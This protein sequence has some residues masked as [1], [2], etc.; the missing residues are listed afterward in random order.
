V[1]FSPV[2]VHIDGFG[3]SLEMRGGRR[4]TWGWRLRWVR[5]GAGGLVTDHVNS[6]QLELAVMAA[7]ARW[8]QVGDETNADEAW[9]H[10][11]GHGRQPEES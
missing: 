1:D 5:R 11:P 6:I 2:A 7:A 3:P 9:S 10:F 8:R 4:T